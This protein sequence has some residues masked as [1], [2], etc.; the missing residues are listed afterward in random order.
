MSKRADRFYIVSA[1]PKI[2]L[3]TFSSSRLDSAVT[4]LYYKWCMEGDNDRA[5]LLLIHSM[6]YH[7][8]NY[9]TSACRWP[10]SVKKWE[11]WLERYSR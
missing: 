10:A 7:D 1:H 9:L 5:G 3:N 8:E 6:W 11:L 4:A 2:P